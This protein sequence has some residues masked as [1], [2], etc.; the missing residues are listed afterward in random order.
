MVEIIGFIISALALFYLFVRQNMPTQQPSSQQRI[1]VEKDEG[2]DLYQ[3]FLRVLE[4]E[5]LKKEKI[6]PKPPSPPK[7]KKKN[8]EVVPVILTERH[9]LSPIEERRLK[10]SV[11]ERRIKSSIENRH[12]ISPLSSYETHTEEAQPKVQEILNRLYDRRDLVI[13]QEIMGKPKSLR[14]E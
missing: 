9:L 11:E 13:Y 3:E 1:R 7:V 14:I 6:Q 12:L 5:N 8:K 2:S 4:G 10:S